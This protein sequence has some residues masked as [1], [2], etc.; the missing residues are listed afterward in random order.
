MGR[1]PATGEASNTNWDRRMQVDIVPSG[2]VSLEMMRDLGELQE[3]LTE[4]GLDAR[5]SHAS[6][7]GVKDGG[8]TIAIGIAGV[9][10]SAVSSLVSVLTYWSSR[11]PSYSVK[12]EA[13]SGTL[14]IS[15]LDPSSVQDVLKR[16][17]EVDPKS[18]L[19]VR[20]TR[21]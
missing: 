13:G 2:V 8:L 15:D 6:I 10:L 3:E 7:P 21:R 11:K 4:A 14:T 17:K 16:L 19:L 9:V 5:G 20:V 18:G 1:G 12:V